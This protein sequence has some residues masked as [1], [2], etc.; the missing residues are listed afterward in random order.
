MK[1]TVRDSIT[2]PSDP[3]TVGIS[4]P[5]QRVTT[6]KEFETD[7]LPRIKALGYNTIQM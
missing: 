7:V 3:L 2:L 1:R 4:S 5:N 6:Y